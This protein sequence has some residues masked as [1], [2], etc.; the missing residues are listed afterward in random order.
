MNN[1]RV[2]II[3][4]GYWGPNLARNFHDIPASD[5]VT[6]ADTKDSSL[7][8]AHSSYPDVTLLNT[9]KYN[10]VRD[11]NHDGYITDDFGK[12]VRYLSR[13]YD[14]IFP[15]RDWEKV[16][17]TYLGERGLYNM[18]LKAMGKPPRSDQDKAHDAVEVAE[19]FIETTKK[20][21]ES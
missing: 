8:R 12:T 1:L 2:G 15:L 14:S 9:S 17:M 21:L 10:A 11:H 16:E 4:F 3:G 5:L 13:R 20:E 19:R 6:I 7:Q 18:L